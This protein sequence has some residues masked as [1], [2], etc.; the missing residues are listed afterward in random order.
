MPARKTAPTT[1][2]LRDGGQ[3]LKDPREALTDIVGETLYLPKDALIR[4]L[5]Y[6]E[7]ARTLAQLLRWEDNEALD[8][9]G[10]HVSAAWELLFHAQ[11][12]APDEKDA[13]GAPARKPRDLPRKIAAAAPVK[14]N[15]RKPKK[16]PIP[17]RGQDDATIAE[18]VPKRRGRPRKAP[19]LENDNNVDLDVDDELIIPVAPLKQKPRGRPRKQS[20]PPAHDEEAEGDEMEDEAPTSIAPTAQRGKKTASKAPQ[21][22][23]EGAKSWGVVSGIN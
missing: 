14:K 18:V 19:T 7:L 17:E 11:E 12:A 20:L 9:I 15:L 16:A 13:P 4:A 5:V 3:E 6:A 1:G 23:K 2:Q 10:Y 21:P 22:F 8:T